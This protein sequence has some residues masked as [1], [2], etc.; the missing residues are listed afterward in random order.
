MTVKIRIARDDDAEEWDTIISKSPHSTIFHSWNWLKITANHTNMELF[1][2]FGI[3][4]NN[5][6]GAFP[7]FF[8]KK[9]PLRMIFSPPPRV[10]IPYLGPILADYDILKQEKREKI[11]INFQE[12]V[13]NF[14]K[15]NLNVNYV[16]VSLPPDLNDPRP[17]TWS[18]YKVK[19]N[20]DYS[21]DT[22]IGINSLYKS[23]DYNKRTDLKKATEQ[24]M[25][26]EIGSKK[27][28]E[29]ILD[30]MDVR[31]A[32]QAKFL[33]VSSDYFLDVFE[34]Y[35]NNMKIFTVIVG[36][37]VVTGIICIN[38][39]DTL[40]GWFG[41]SKPKNRISPSPNHL[42]FWEIVRYA[43]ENGFK[44]YTIMGAAGNERLHDFYAARFNPKLR[45]RYAAVNK[46][47][48]TGAFEKGY[49]DILKPLRGKIKHLLPS[50]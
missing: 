8:Q 24:G 7:L 38:Y 16:S 9:G 26:V 15:N 10:S 42:L 13:D 3:K 22:S 11:Y 23:L 4:D 50:T 29:K 36:G 6:I 39:R 47:L 41:N 14:I 43:S 19:P 44:N 45:I 17:F 33:T 12:S 31:Y 48:L 21:V 1:P 35:K 20:Y 2:L 28:Y 40:F 37:E 25:I 18:G 27:E 49:T 32:Q 34:A 5:L 30:L 46:T